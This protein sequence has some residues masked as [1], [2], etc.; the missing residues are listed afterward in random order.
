MSFRFALFAFVLWIIILPI[1]AATAESW[2]HFCITDM[3]S[4]ETLCTT[5]LSA[6]FNGAEFV[7]YFAH[8]SEGNP[9]FVAAGPE[10][11]YSNMTI[12]VDDEA[13]LSADSCEI[14]LCFLKTEKSGVL[15]EQFKRGR[16][17]HIVM[18]ASQRSIGFDREISLAGFSAAFNRE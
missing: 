10:R 2:D 14:G 5:E 3:E 15:L 7:F 12:Q 1:G 4:E 6:S 13:A 18:E 17:A 16:K 9:P 11:L 8:T